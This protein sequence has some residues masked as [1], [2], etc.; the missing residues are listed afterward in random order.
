MIHT[1]AFHSR[2]RMAVEA[3]GLS[4][5]RIRGRLAEQG[6][7]VS[8]ST[9]SNW[10]RGVSRPGVDTRRVVAAL[11]SVL[12]VDDGAL[13]RLLGD[14]PQAGRRRF[15]G[16]GTSMERLRAL[17][18]KLEVSER[19][20]SVVA[21][22]DEA[23]V[24]ERDRIRL[25]RSR[26]VV[27]ADRPGADRHVVFVHAN[28][29]TLPVLRSTKGCEVGRTALDAEAGLIA[30]ELRFGPLVRGETYPIEY[31]VERMESGAYYGRWIRAADVRYELTVWF[32]SGSSVRSAYR[33]WRSDARSPHKD[34]CEVRLI[35]D[36]VAHMID[37]DPNPG[38][39]GIRWT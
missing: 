25:M 1:S 5:E 32:E 17:R 7:T 11:E 36:E 15:L 2:L 29:R 9:L 22:A 35:G 14:G 21:V 19:D 12:H 34:V 24:A 18:A 16:P 6:V 8:V 28:Q 33:V 39:H 27:R 3:R 23:V 30:A 38:F 20:L 4:L 10:Q 31:Q 37:D 26:L 13:T